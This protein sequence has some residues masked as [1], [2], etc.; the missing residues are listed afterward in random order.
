MSSRY[1][2][3]VSPVADHA[4]APV[5]VDEV[6]G[7]GDRAVDHVQVSPAPVRQLEQSA[8]SLGLGD[9]WSAQRVVDRGRVS[10]GSKRIRLGEDDLLVLLVG[11]D[12][13]PGFGD[14]LEGLVQSTI[15]DAREADRIDLDR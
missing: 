5:P 10:S 13:S 11:C 3:H 8:G 9:R 6:E 14:H 12:R 2:R 4:L 1:W 15:R 7:P